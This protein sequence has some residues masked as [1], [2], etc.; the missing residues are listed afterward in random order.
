MTDALALAAEL[1]QITN[2]EWRIGCP[3]ARTYIAA[4]STRAEAER[5][6]AAQPLLPG[7]QVYS[8][9]DGRPLLRQAAETLRSQHALLNRRSAAASRP[10]GKARMTVKPAEIEA[11]RQKLLDLEARL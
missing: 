3:T 11:L 7:H 4:F 8:Y 2:V 10:A 1:E 9:A 5:K 6:A